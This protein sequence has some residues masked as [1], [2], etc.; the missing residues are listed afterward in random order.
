MR[1]EFEQFIKDYETHSK[2]RTAQGIPPLPLSLAQTQ[3]AIEM[4]K[5]SSVSAEYKAFAKELIIHRV[6]PGVDTSAQ[7]KAEFLGAI[8]LENK[9]DWGFSQA[10]AITYLGTM[11]GGYNVAPLIKGLSLSDNNLAKA[12]AEALKHTLLIYDNFE[13]IAALN[14]PLSQEIIQSWADAEWFKCKE[15]LQEKI[16]VCVFKVD[17]ET[18]TD[19]LSPAGDAFTRSDIPLHAKAMLKSRIENFESRIENAKKKAQENNAI[20]AYVGD[21]VGTGSSRKSACNSIMWHFGKEIPFIPNKKSG[22]IVIGSVIAPIFFNTCEDSG[23][24]PI[25]ADVSKLQ[26]G[27]II[28]IDTLKGEISKNGEVVATF[29]LN[30]VTLADEIRSGGKSHSSSAEA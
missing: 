4:C 28:E 3:N 6:N 22:G 23:A 10:E 20:V 29:T 9:Q 17:G 14:T 19:D 16:K 25:V 24:L 18:N 13:K 2:E 12:C 5:N 8:L 15:G 30:P 7:L 21:V 26:D 11:L 27:D 1:E